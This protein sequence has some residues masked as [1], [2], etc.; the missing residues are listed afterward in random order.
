MTYDVSHGTLLDNLGGVE[1]MIDHIG[2]MPSNAAKKFKNKEALCFEGKSFTFEELSKLIEKFS[3][4]LSSLGIKEKD[5]VTLYASNSWEW[6]VSYFSI[7]RIGAIINPVN[8]MLTPSEIKHVVNDCKAKAIIT[9]SDKVQSI[10]NIKNETGVS[11][12]ISFGK[13]PQGAEAFNNLIEKETKP[14]EMPNISH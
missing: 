5:V 11:T 9:S 8:T 12:L 1:A 13:A 2:Q 14:I 10:I 6:I 4:S 7:A 3:S